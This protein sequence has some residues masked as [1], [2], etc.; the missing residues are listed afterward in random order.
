MNKIG[1]IAYAN[2]GGVGIQTRRLAKL[3]NPDKILVIDSSRFSKNKTQHF[4]WYEDFDCTISNGFPTPEVVDKFL[5]GLTHLLTVENPYSIYMIWK[6]QQLG[7]KYCCQVN[8]EFSDNVAKPYYPVPDLFLMPSYWKLKEMKEM[9]GEDKVIYLPPPLD[10]ADFKIEPLHND[11]PQF[12]HIVGTLA[13]KD[14][15]GTVELLNAIKISKGDYKITI[16]SQ[17][18]L[19]TQF[20]VDDQRIT[21]RVENFENNVDIYKGFDAL[22]FPRRYG[23]LSLTT[24]EALMSGMPVMMTDCSPNNEWLPK[25]WLIPV[26]GSEEIETKVKIDSYTVDV[27][28]LAQKMDDWAKNCPKPEIARKLGVDNFSTAVLEPRYRTLLQ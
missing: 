3:L 22:I 9:F 7:I 24:N 19:P 26:S 18:P 23:G 1:L 10:P 14:R 12:L 5:P 27:Q 25:D 15:N 11:T 6:A 21:Y 28:S 17:H 13:Y 8:Y 2:D 4:E 20:I 16:H